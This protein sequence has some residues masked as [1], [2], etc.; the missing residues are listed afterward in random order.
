MDT[1]LP[2]LPP[3]PRESQ[4]FDYG[5]VVVV[6]GSLGM[7]GAP[8]LTAM[9]ALRSG[10][11]L[12]EL[13]V[14]EPVA[15][16]AAGFDPCVMTRGLPS[17]DGGFAESAAA[18]IRARAAKADAVACGP[19]LGRSAAAAAILRLLW[20]E[21]PRPLVVDADGI[22][23]LANGIDSAAPRRARLV[24]PHAGE[25]AALL[26]G[27]ELDQNPRSSREQLEDAAAG[28]AAARG[29][30]VILKGSRTLVTDGSARHH[31]PTGNP[32]MATAGAGD[33]LT[34][35]VAALIGQG[36]EPLP[37]ARLAA[38]VHGRAGDLAAA[39]IG[40]IS[41]VATDLVHWLPAAFRSLPGQ[42]DS[43]GGVA[44]ARG[45]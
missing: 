42:S 2:L 45:R 14:P 24:T 40:E 37:A 22:R 33:V 41:L 11:G 16:V 26:D 31:N 29:A 23:A 28:W 44:T 36:L 13:L 25:M 15:A 27:L 3:R 4:K 43:D 1:P 39:A 32:G 21:C 6:G 5:R 19:G 38:F 17:T 34:G 30:I 7:A 10:A 12:V 18:E 35:I 20:Q 9:A 8:A